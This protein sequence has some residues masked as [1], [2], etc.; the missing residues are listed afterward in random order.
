MGGIYKPIGFS[1]PAKKKKKS[2]KRPAL[3][4]KPTPWVYAQFT[5]M[6]SKQEMHW[7]A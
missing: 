6:L 5:D 4:T 3:Y 1:Q 2:K 7:L